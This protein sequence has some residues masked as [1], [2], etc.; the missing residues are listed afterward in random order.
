M[1]SVKFEHRRMQYAALTLAAMMAASSA[2]GAGTLSNTSIENTASVN[3]S[4]SGIAQEVIESSPTGNST[5]GAGA[6]T[7]TGFV[8]D[9]LVDLLVAEVGGATTVMTPGDTDG[10]AVFTVTNEGN[11]AQDYELSPS[12]LTPGDPDVHGN[13]DSVDMT[14]FQVFVDGT[15]NGTYE[16]GTDT[17][18]FIGSLAPD[19]TVTVFVLANAPLGAA[20]T[21][22]AN[23][24][25]TVITHDAGSGAAAVTAETA[26]ADTPGTVDVVFGEGAG[27]AY[28]G[29]EWADDGYSFVTADL[30]ISKTS[31]VVSD[32]FNGGTN[33]KA[34]PGAV[35]EYTISIVNNGSVD[36]TDIAI[37]D[38]LPTD[39]IA[40]INQYDGATADVAIQPEAGPDT[41]CTFAADADGCDL[42]GVGGSGEGGTLTI[43]PPA[44]LTIGSTPG[45]DEL[46]I[47]FSVTIR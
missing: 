31:T 9:N 1:K 20:S 11:T 41:F 40:L 14:A 16:A 26:G 6:G 28:D 33:P 23:V 35:V 43:D 5:S 12:N 46:T 19:A 47:L 8:V 3:Y 10:L 18:T 36:A 39:V 44:G 37:T 25:L 34:I 7:P 30:V 32:P 17:A 22:F 4:V 13:T 2:W 38:V 21:D 27:P 24:R 15:A 42:G 45:T 29:Q